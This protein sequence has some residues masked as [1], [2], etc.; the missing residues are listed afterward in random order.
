MGYYSSF[1]WDVSWWSL[2]FSQKGAA[3]GLSLLVGNPHIM[4]IIY[5]YRIVWIPL[6]FGRQAP[7]TFTPDAKFK[8]LLNFGFSEWCLISYFFTRFPWK[9]ALPPK[10]F[11][12]IVGKKKPSHMTGT[13]I[14]FSSNPDM[15]MLQWLVKSKM[16]QPRIY[17][18]SYS[19]KQLWFFNQ[20]LLLWWSWWWCH[21]VLFSFHCSLGSLDMQVGH[22]CKRFIIGSDMLYHCI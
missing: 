16:A 13:S 3:T 8:S 21:S 20:Q 22:S 11:P 1:N 5:T 18:W 6:F 9:A 2:A 15:S 7:S 12:G 19:H 4:T 10:N 17:A 14:F